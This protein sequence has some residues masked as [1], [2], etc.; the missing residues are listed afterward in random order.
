MMTRGF[1]EESTSYPSPSR[2]I[3]PGVKFSMTTSAF[4]TS[5][6][7]R[8]FPSAERRSIEMLRFPR[9]MLKK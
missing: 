2:P 9:L 6:R 3:V 4:S 8:S 7:K 5:R 1:M